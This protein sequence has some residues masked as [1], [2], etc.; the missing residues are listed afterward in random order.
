MRIQD[1]VLQDMLEENCRSYPRKLAVVCGDT[2]Y[3]YPQLCERIYRLAN[4]FAAGGRMLWLGQNS[5]RVLEGLLACAC[6]GA[7]FC[8]VNWRQ[9]PSDSPRIAA[10]AGCSTT[11]T[12]RTAM[13]RRS[14]PHRRTGKR[15]PSIPTSRC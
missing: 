2:G 4:V 8:P 6:I 9:T 14:P 12:V 5:H 10:A 1:W 13:K 3:T 15:A 11:A 7:N